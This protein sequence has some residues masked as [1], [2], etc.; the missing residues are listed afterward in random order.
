MPEE[1]EA[2]LAK[3]FLGRLARG[4]VKSI[5]IAGSIIEEAIFGTLDEKA[6]KEETAKLHIALAEIQRS[7]GD[8]QSIT[9]AE[10]LEMLTAQA[11]FTTKT[12]ENI[13]DLILAVRDEAS[14]AV[15]EKTTQLIGR[16]LD[17]HGHQ[18][19]DSVGDLDAQ[20]ARL[21][22]TISRIQV[23]QSM[24]FSGTLTARKVPP[25]EREA[26]LK[27][28]DTVETGTRIPSTRRQTIFR[29]STSPVMLDLVNQFRLIPTRWDFDGIGKLE[30]YF[31]VFLEITNNSNVF[32]TITGTTGRMKIH[33]DVLTLGSQVEAEA[34]DPDQTIEVE[35]LQPV[36]SHM[37]D[38]IASAYK[39]QRPLQVDLTNFGLALILAQSMNVN[40]YVG[41]KITV[42]LQ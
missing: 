3:I 35:V 7:V 11:E 37:S 30:P 25:E 27:S 33:G 21:E 15:S 14:V 17:R 42:N 22:D 32:G 29:P 18:L 28:M 23:P 24:G 36:T 40:V 39:R 41:A 34:V 31:R 26:A 8:V 19:D 20:I 1:N 5:P 9:L 2:G 10:V 12:Q 16:F 38:W 6:A 13:E 4:G